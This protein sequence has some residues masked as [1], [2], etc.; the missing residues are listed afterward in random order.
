MSPCYPNV[1]RGRLSQELGPCSQCSRRGAGKF[2]RLH[3]P[4]TTHHVPRPRWAFTLIEI[5]IVVGIMGLVLTMGVPIVY[6]VFHRAPLNQAVA[7]IFEVLSNA[8]ARAIMQGKIVNVVFHPRENRLEIQDANGPAAGTG[9]VQV[10]LTRGVGAGTSARLSDRILIEMLDINKQD[11]DFKDYDSAIV[12]F[13]PNSMAD[14]LTL[15]L[16]SERGEE[17]GITLEIT[18]G[19]ANV[20]SDAQVQELKARSR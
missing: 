14:E 1:I 9:Q 2:P 19:L 16:V 5:M 10:G 15:L 6:K 7:D 3:A 11:H 12:R 4:R 17:R 20:L 8:R 13:F 18:T